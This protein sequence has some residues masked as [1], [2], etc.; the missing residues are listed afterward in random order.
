MEY[1]ANLTTLPHVSFLNRF[2][3]KGEWTHFRRRNGEFI[4]YFLV[5]GA[6]H[7]REEGDEYSL[8]PGD[9]FLLQP[10]LLHE[11]VK[12][13][14]C[15]YYFVHFSNLSLLPLGAM[16]DESLITSYSG[17]GEVKFDM[18]RCVLPKMSHIDSAET[19]A[20]LGACFEEAIAA[21]REGAQNYR[22]LWACKLLE[23]LM[24]VSQNHTQAALARR[25]GQL[26][27]RTLHRLEALTAYLNT[28]YGEKVTSKQLESMTG[29]NFDYLNRVFRKLNGRSVFQYLTWVRMNRAK[30]LLATTDMKLWE[31][32]AETGFSDQFYFSRQFKKYTGV[33]PA[34]FGRSRSG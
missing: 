28:H 9:V 1:L 2:V 20:Q 29:L 30:E 14:P 11:G 13:A 19:R 12:P 33:P 4:L 16:P 31:I 21:A 7:L 32:A 25:S 5:D 3:P 8:G 34:L 24:L 26:P 18:E 23:I 10:S 15:D 17:D 6:M 22:T 27:V